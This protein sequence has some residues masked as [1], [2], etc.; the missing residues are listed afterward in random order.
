MIARRRK[1]KRK[2]GNP[3]FYKG[4]PS[5][6]PSVR[7]ATVRWLQEAAQA[8]GKKCIDFLVS[9]RDDEHYH[10]QYRLQATAMLLDRGYGKA[11]QG[12][13]IAHKNLDA[14]KLI[15]REMTAREA[16]YQYMKMLRGGL[17]DDDP[18][19]DALD[20]SFASGS[21]AVIDVKAGPSRAGVDD[22]DDDDDDE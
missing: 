22:D 12:A 2:P 19:G 6:N 13:V 5:Y 4:M 14:P 20:L 3:A 1:G 8:Q 9:V 15:T 17:E 16:Q 18:D 11:I 21:R 7:P 10:I